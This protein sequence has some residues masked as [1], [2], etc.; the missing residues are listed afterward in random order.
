MRVLGTI[1]V[2]L[3]LVLVT[4]IDADTLPAKH[5]HLGSLSGTAKALGLPVPPALLQRA[6]QVIE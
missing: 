1:A 5:V 4:P 6:D 3:A 2:V